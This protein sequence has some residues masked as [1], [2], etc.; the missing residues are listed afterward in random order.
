MELDKLTVKLTW[1][2]KHARFINGGAF[3]QD[4]W[5]DDED[6]KKEETE[7]KPG[8]HWAPPFLFFLGWHLV[9]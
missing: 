2:H 9:L 6:E 3:L 1:K 5:D 4:N 8:E 7:V